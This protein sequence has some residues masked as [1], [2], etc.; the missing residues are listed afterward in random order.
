[1]CDMWLSCHAS[2][3]CRHTDEHTRLDPATRGRRNN[4]FGDGEQCAYDLWDENYDS[5]QSE[6]YN[7]VLFTERLVSTI[8]S[9]DP[10][11]PFMAYYGTL[12]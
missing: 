6:T 8:R 5:V 4:A 11:T 9:A 12:G 2:A 1:M 3:S 7:E 10:D